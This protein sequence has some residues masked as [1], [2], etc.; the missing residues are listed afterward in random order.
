MFP[1]PLGDPQKLLLAEGVCLQVT[2]KVLGTSRQ[3]VDMTQQDTCT[4]WGTRV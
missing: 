1:S 4:R 3:L 2:A